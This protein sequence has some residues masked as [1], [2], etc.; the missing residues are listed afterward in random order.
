MKKMYL[1]LFIIT[2]VVIITG[3]WIYQV[4]ASTSGLALISEYV[5][6]GIIVILF[7][8]G[9]FLA[10]RRIKST[11]KGLPAE[12]E[13]SKRIEQKAASKSF[14]VS[15]FLWLIIMYLQDRNGGESEIYFGYGIIGMAVIFATFYIYYY[16]K[17]NFNE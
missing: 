5:Q 10:I 1:P 4:K 3:I 13:L 17:G 6:V 2:M 12:D 7:G 14:F 11:S 16:F 8:F 9:I 15:L